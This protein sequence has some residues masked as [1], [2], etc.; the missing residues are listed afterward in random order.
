[1]PIEVS[2]RIKCYKVIVYQPKSIKF[3][4]LRVNQ[5]SLIIFALLAVILVSFCIYYISCITSKLSMVPI[6]TR[7]DRSDS[8][9]SLKFAPILYINKK[10]Y[11]NLDDLFVVIHPVKPVIAYHLFWKDDIDFPDDG[12]PNDH[13]IIW[14]FYNDNR[15]NIACLWT[16]WHGKILKQKFSPEDRIQHPSVYIQ[17]GKHGS[18]PSD[19]E[20]KFSLRPKVE[21]FFQYI[22][23]KYIHKHN[24]S[25]ISQDWPE[26]FNG[27]FKDYKDFSFKLH[28]ELFIQKDK[29]LVGV[30]ANQM[31]HRIYS[32]NFSFKREWPK[33]V[34]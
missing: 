24:R 30:D 3:M 32:K 20:R 1:M 21:F 33:E 23:C 6:I 27:S 12:Q 9:L 22:L 11:F 19:W 2:E 13:E 15:E 28:L 8:Q 18:M 17:W 14:V 4:L 34:E 29:I 26:I 5:T 31:I 10:E 7:E 16:Y 25:E